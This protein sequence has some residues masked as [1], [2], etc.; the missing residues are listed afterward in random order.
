[1]P[2]SAVVSVSAEEASTVT[3]GL[4]NVPDGGAPDR[5]QVVADL[6]G[7]RAS[8]FR[9]GPLPPHRRVELLLPRKGLVAGSYAYV[10]VLWAESNPGRR[11][12][13]VS[14]VSEA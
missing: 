7:R 3:A 1:M 9:S 13:F 8:S 6:L 12:V 2:L 4:V 5:R 10:V 14:P 11:S